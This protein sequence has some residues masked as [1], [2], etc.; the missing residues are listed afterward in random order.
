[1]CESASGSARTD[2][3]GGSG[4]EAQEGGREWEGGGVTVEGCEDSKRDIRCTISS[5]SS[6]LQ[7][8]MLDSLLG[9]FVCSLSTAEPD[10]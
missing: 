10:Q 8:K 7:N 4:G 1:M 6:V 9:K 3:P 2:S 5:A